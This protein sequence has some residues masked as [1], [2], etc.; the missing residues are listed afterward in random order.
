MPATANVA[1]T[2]ATYVKISYANF[3]NMTTPL[4]L[5]DQYIAETVEYANNPY[6]L[7]NDMNLAA[8]V[9]EVNL[10]NQNQTVTT[11]DISKVSVSGLTNP[12]QLAFPASNNQNLT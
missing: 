10:Y 11:N 2:E 4:A 8:N 12:I 5:N 3:I 1:K 7:G 6:Q 9:L